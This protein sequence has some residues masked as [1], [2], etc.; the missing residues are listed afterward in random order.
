MKI[1]FPKMISLIVIAVYV[2]TS[3][4]GDNK[5][6]DPEP[7]DTTKPEITVTTPKA[8]GQSYGINGGGSFMFEGT[9]KDDVELKE[10]IFSLSNS[11]SG[12]SAALKSA[13]GIYDKPWEPADVTMELS[14]TADEVNQSIFEDPT[15]SVWTGNYTLT[16]TCKD[17]AGNSS[18]KSIDVTIN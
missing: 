5:K 12:T 17:K 13:T 1:Y 2:L 11:K 16:I 7:T 3:C 9:F 6:K 18:S 14:G 4:G 8:S 15:E 10:V